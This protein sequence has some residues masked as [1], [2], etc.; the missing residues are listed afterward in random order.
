MLAAGK[1]LLAAFKSSEWVQ[2]HEDRN[3]RCRK[4][5]LGMCARGRSP[6]ECPAHR[7]PGPE[8]QTRQGGRD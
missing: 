6:G 1:S 5:R 7:R 8:P 2:D 4:G 3:R